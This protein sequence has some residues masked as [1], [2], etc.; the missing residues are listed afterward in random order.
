MLFISWSKFNIFWNMIFN[1]SRWFL[2][3]DES[4]IASLLFLIA[5]I[6][7]HIIL[8]FDGFFLFHLRLIPFLNHDFF[9][10]LWF[11]IAYFIEYLY[12]WNFFRCFNKLRLLLIYNLIIFFSFVLFLFLHNTKFRSKQLSFIRHWIR[13][14][15]NPVIYTSPH[16]NFLLWFYFHYTWWCFI[17]I[18]PFYV[19]KRIHHHVCF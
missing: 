16:A 6:H 2:L 14:D 4:E 3:F 8:E 17:L 5:S 13:F 18:R 1:L 15:L 19:V 10:W 7:I 12:W 11:L 9:F